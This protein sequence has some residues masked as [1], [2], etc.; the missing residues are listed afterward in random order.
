[1]LFLLRYTSAATIVSA[2]SQSVLYFFLEKFNQNS[3]PTFPIPFLNPSA[4]NELFHLC[5]ELEVTGGDQPTVKDV[6]SL[7]FE[8]ITNAALPSDADSS[9]DPTIRRLKNTHRR[10][11]RAH[12]LRHNRFIRPR[13]LANQRLLE[14]NVDLSDLIDALSVTGGYNGEELFIKL[15]LD[16]SKLSVNSIE[17]L[18]RKPF[19]ILENVKLIEALFPPTD[20]ST[21]G[22]PLLNSS[23]SFSAGAHAG[24]RGKYFFYWNNSQFVTL[25]DP[26]SLFG[27]LQ[28]ESI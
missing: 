14:D 24:V 27:S 5:A 16:V 3:D 21:G 26:I 1:M 6:L 9:K 22:K 23:I 11:L 20:N 10:A 2:P 8:E 25:A 7:L 15:E 4:K 17:D 19:E 12:H 13:R 18:V 28:L